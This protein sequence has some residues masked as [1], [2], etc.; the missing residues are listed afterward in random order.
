[1]DLFTLLVIGY[2]LFGL[3]LMWLSF[4]FTRSI[5]SIAIR[6]AIPAVVFAFWFTPGA[7]VG[8]GGAML[9]PMW[10]E[11]YGDLSRYQEVRANEAA[12]QQ[13]D[14]TLR[15]MSPAHATPLQIWHKTIGEELLMFAA[16]WLA[17]YLV[18]LGLAIIR[19]WLQKRTSNRHIT[20]ST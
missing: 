15:A 4:R 6:A 14:S 12:Y 9:V 16:V 17:A 5:R 19:H 3:G 18:I 2:P 10:M 13:L 8:E 1:M 7:A 11:F 20:E